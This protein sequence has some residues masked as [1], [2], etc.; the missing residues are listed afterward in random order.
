MKRRAFFAGLAAAMGITAE[1]SA[2]G[3][4]RSSGSYGGGRS[5]S[6]GSYSSRGANIYSGTGSN[7][8]SHSRSGYVRRDTGTYVAPHHATNPNST[9]RD[10]YEAR[11]NYNPHNGTT[12][13]RLVDR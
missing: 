10:N 8:M 4:G 7:S 6:G 1:A 9:R 2:R 5:Y 12:G 13:R 3:G 11:G